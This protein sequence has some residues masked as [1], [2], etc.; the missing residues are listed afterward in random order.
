MGT[1]ALTKA[2]LRLG[3]G[4]VDGQHAYFSQGDPQQR[5]RVS[6]WRSDVDGH[7]VEVT[8][9]DANVRSTVNEYGGGAWAVASGV[10]IYADAPGSAIWLIKPDCEPRLIV[11]HPG[12]R[13][14][15]FALYPERNIALT[16]REDHRSPGEPV[17]TV[18]ALRIDDPNL[19][20]GVV[21]LSGADFYAHPCLS[22]DGYLAWCEW[23]HPYMPWDQAAIW[24]APLSDLSSRIAVADAPDVS[25]LYP[26]WAPDGALIYLSDASGYWNFYRWQHGASQALFPA[27]HD[28]CGPLWVLDPVPYAIIDEASIGC[29]WFEDGV[30]AVGTLDFSGEHH[31]LV[32]LDSPAVTA[33]VHGH[34][35]RSVALLGFPDR[36]TELATVDWRTKA[37]H[38][39]RTS[40]ALGLESDAISR[41]QP[42]T[43]PSADGPVRA[44]YYPPTN[45]Q[46]T[47]CP[48]ERPPLQVWS[49]SGPTSIATAA[50]NP[51]VQ[52]WTSRGIA[53]L[54]V[55]YL[56]SSGYGRAYRQRLIGDWGVIDVRDCVAGVNVLATAG[57]ID[58][59]RVSIRGSS[60]GGFTTL[61]ALTTT[62]VFRAG[63]SLYGI[64]D[65]DALLVDS[66][67]FESRYTARLLGVHGPD[68]RSY[69]QRSPIRHLD[70]LNCP[71]LV[72]QGDQDTVVPVSQA[73]QLVA[74]VKRAGH[75]AELHIFHGEG[76]GFR[77]AATIKAVAEESLAFLG[78]VFG[79][80]PDQSR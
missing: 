31:Q 6:L 39:L 67:K 78:S 71:M 54:D 24:T 14:A 21:L 16:V 63:I 41:A 75:H 48:G 44:W 27:D 26:S 45:P 50:F 23:N 53:I 35:K 55:N 13:Y 5:G 73:E 32:R 57:L 29:S 59:Q 19:D 28:F 7:S 51:Q 49:H 66:H 62:D 42:V 69:Q 79:F 30:A 12:L 17:Q 58:P 60:A 72:F 77:Q 3:Y 61:A 52:Y 37:I 34:G 76:H 9:P 1:A 20:G 56:G 80:V 33:D 40:G 74:A 68:D 43:W 11:E 65:L 47:G 46:F 2:S 4:I 70:R 64:A 18:V 38:G 10:V 25:S 36:P 22:A 8:P 15:G